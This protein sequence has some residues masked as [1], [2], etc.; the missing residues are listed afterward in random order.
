MLGNGHTWDSASAR[1]WSHFRPHASCSTWELISSSK[2]SAFCFP[3]PV[4]IAIF[5]LRG[6]VYPIIINLSYFLKLISRIALK[7]RD[8][9]CTVHL[10]SAFFKTEVHKLQK[11]LSSKKKKMLRKPITIPFLQFQQLYKLTLK[12]STKW[13]TQGFTKLPR[14]KFNKTYFTKTHLPRD[15]YLK[16]KVDWYLQTEWVCLVYL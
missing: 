3:C 16:H 5:F 9:A 10:W 2:I 15:R 1:Q 6:T 7:A 11:Q 4:T 13:G 8:R 12:S 14:T